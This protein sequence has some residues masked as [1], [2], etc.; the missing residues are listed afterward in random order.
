MVESRY[1]MITP[2]AALETVLAHTPLLGSE[3][4]ALTAARD[5]VLAEDV[6]APFDL[7]PFAASAVDGYAVVSDDPSETR[8]VVGQ[9]MAGQ[10]RELVVVP[11]AA[12][13]TMTGAPVA[14]GADAVAMVE[15]VQEMDGQI[16]LTRPVRAGENVRPAG[17]DLRAG[18]LVLARGTSVGPAEM[19][20]LASVGL[21]EVS[22]FLRPRVAVLSTGDE[23][24]EPWEE[25]GPARIR[26]SNRYALMAAVASAG[27]VPVSLGMVR[28]VRY[29]QR[30]RIR[31][32]LEIA[33]VLITSGGVSV[34]L[35]DLVKGILEE[36]G[37]VHVGRVFMKPGKPLTF[38]T[39]GRKVAFGLPGFPV[40]SLVTFELFVR[41][42]L[43]KMQG[44]SDLER[45]RVEA[46]LDHDVTPAEDR[47]EYQRA[48][49]RWED[50][51][52]RASSTGSQSSSRLLS[53]VGSNALLLFSPGRKR[54][55]GERVTAILTG[56]ICS[57]R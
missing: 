28:D 24:V 8:R 32:G 29:R 55:A 31:R 30:D 44:R 16:A 53:M 27:G 25:A 47:S 46:I 22:L 50:G 7:P 14:P 13:R 10:E 20:L 41:P 23:L 43:L 12:V 5:R 9:V 21:R 15:Y 34:G 48:V 56:P 37:T 11:G 19:G 45:P 4:V 36:I 26:D 40:S 39:V 3:M 2:D 49:V 52:L 35:R 33:D 51:E 1:E 42:S 17:Q 6:V 57:R 18:D 54:R 38:A